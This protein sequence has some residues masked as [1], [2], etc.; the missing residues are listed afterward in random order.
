MPYRESKTG[1]ALPTD[2]ISMNDLVAAFHQYFEVISVDSPVLLAEVFRIRHQIVCVEK[3]FSDLQINGC[4]DGLE[5]DEYDAR[6]V[7]ILIRH[8]PSNKFVGTARLVLA[9][10]PHPENPFPIE[11]RVHIDHTMLHYHKPYRLHTAEISRLIILTRFPHNE[12]R[13]RRKHELGHPIDKAT[14]DRLRFIYPVLALVVGIIRMSAD[15]N[16]THWYATM[17]PALCRLLGYFGLDLQAIGPLNSYAKRPYFAKIDNVLEKTY[18]RRRDVWELVTDHGRIWPEPHRQSQGF[19]SE[20]ILYPAS[21]QGDNNS[22]L[23]S[24][25]D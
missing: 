11:Q 24:H 20:D 10:W 2:K 5:T 9:D 25:I 22:Q 16:V 15:N 19:I 3:R 14:S 1:A 23:E 6:S 18:H 13:H 12:I 4:P 17:D 7:H 21:H 8:R